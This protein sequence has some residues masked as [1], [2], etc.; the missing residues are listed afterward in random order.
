[1]KEQLGIQD[2]REA[3][4]KIYNDEI[5]RP[6]IAHLARTVM[7]SSENG[8]PLASAI[9]EQ[10]AQELF[11]LARSICQSAGFQDDTERVLVPAGGILKETSPVLQQFKAR[12]RAEMPEMQLIQ[13][14]FP[15]VVGA[16]ILGLQLVGVS[17]LGKVLERIQETLPQLPSNALKT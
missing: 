14:R 16:F 10:E 11:I 1:V 9:I 4:S 3:Q 6:E 13:P 12:I 17:I 7:Q 15:P 8:D 5:R 2:M